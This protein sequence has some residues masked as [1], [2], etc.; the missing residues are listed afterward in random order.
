VVTVYL[1]DIDKGLTNTPIFAYCR[2]LIKEGVDPNE[3]LEVYRKGKLNWDIKINN[4]GKGAELTVD[5]SVGCVLAKY[6]HP[7]F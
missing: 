4:I 2:K 1:E 5:E 3:E 7:G 6:R